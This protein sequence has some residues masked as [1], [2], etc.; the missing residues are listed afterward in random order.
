MSGAS[1]DAPT[2]ESE[3]KATKSRI[4]ELERELA[5]SESVRAKLEG[6][7]SWRLTAPLRDPRSQLRDIG[8]RLKFR[9]QS[10]ANDAAY[11]RSE[12]G[13]RIDRSRNNLASVGA[14]DE[15]T[16]KWL[17]TLTE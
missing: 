4:R 6:S 15:A 7:R 10:L 14:F 3:L 1:V 5:A 13:W 17:E 12:V 9:G 16:P 8:V 11:V 2:L